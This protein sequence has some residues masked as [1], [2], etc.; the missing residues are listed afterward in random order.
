[1]NGNLQKG[2]ITIFFSTQQVKKKNLFLHKREKMLESIFFSGKKER[3][4]NQNDGRIGEAFA[5]LS[6]GLLSFALHWKQEFDGNQ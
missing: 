2:S 1:M 5:L 4:K 3:F 6:F